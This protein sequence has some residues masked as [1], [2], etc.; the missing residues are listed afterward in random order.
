MAILIFGDNFSFPE[1]NAGTNRLYTY[2][3]GFIENNVNTYVICFKNDYLVNGNGIVDRIQ[4][5]NPLNQSKKNSSFFVR[6]W[7]KV[8]KFMNTLRLVKKIN[9]QDEISAIIVDTQVILTYL[10]SYYLA[11]KINSK[12]IVENSEHPLR[13]YRKGFSKVIIGNLK[14]KLQLNT[15]DGIMLITQSLIDLKKKM[16]KNYYW[17]HLQLTHPDFP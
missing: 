4:Y 1:G 10:L 12:L 17:C 13:Y 15:F 11:K 3:K 7:F 14:L 8:V 16:T 9:K 5:F 2:A 6:N